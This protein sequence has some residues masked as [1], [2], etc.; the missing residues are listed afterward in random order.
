MTFKVG[1][2]G[3][4]RIGKSF[5]NVFEENSE[6]FTVQCIID[7]SIDIGNILYYLNYDSTYKNN[8]LWF[9]DSDSSG[10]RHS[11]SKN[12]IQ[13]GC[14]I[15]EKII[16]LLCSC[17]F[18]VDATSSGLCFDLYQDRELPTIFSTRFCSQKSKLKNYYLGTCDSN[19]ILPILEEISIKGDINS[20]SVVIVH[21]A[22]SKQPSLDRLPIGDDP[23]NFRSALSNIIPRQTGLTNILIKNFPDI[24]HINTYCYR[25]PTHIVS[26]AHV[27]LGM[28]IKDFTISSIVNSLDMYEINYDPI[29]SS[30]IIGYGKNVI[31]SNSIFEDIH[32]LSF[33][34]GYDNEIGYV[35]QCVKQIRNI[36]ND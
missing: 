8:L 28:K 30:D 21:P 18:L 10:Y 32:T 29:V 24:S 23:A 14:I 27:S 15:D 1:I 22:L 19:A 17:D 16:E 2:L 25:V 13:I 20:I 11:E 12:S 33:A 7:N 6:H 31:L 5:L 3:F 4:G 34:I 36:L 35:K 9:Y 26:F